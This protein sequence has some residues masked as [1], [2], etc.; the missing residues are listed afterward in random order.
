MD[1]EVN[2]KFG[3]L[4][5]AERERQGINLED[6]AEKLKIVASN[7][8]AIEDGDA[9]ALPSEL[10]FNLFSKTYSESL[11][12][13]YV[14][15]IDAIKDDLNNKPEIPEKAGDKNNEKKTKDKE[16]TEG[17]SSEKDYLKKGA[18]LIGGLVVILIV[19]LL[20]NKFVFSNGEKVT[21]E[22][23]ADSQSVQETKKA[24]ELNSTYA[25][26]DWNTPEYKQ[27]GKLTLILTPRE[28]SWSTVVA[29]G[30]TVIYRTL[31]PGR[32]YR[33]E[34]DYRLL[35]SVGIP[36]VV[37]TTLNGKEVNLRDPET[38]RI[39]R[40]LINQMNL[41]KFLNPPPPPPTKQEIDE[42]PKKATNENTATSAPVEQTGNTSVKDTNTISNDTGAV[43]NEG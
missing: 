22:N 12:I 5:K 13:D 38:R 29:D 43:I 3:E 10:Y 27:P 37:K 32:V 40:V 18:Y 20:L 42:P 19:F 4:L 21:T 41:D 26:Y 28:E 2:K 16:D 30:D 14:R 36:S 6:L 31:V 1:I 9:S 11:G 15:T 34:A 8:K 7:L 33:A 24:D 17:E 35:V 23:N 39:S 25:N